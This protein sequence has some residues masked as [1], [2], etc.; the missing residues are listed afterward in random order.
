MFLDINNVDPPGGAVWCSVR[1]GWYHKG[2][3]Q[4]TVFG[5]CGRFIIEDL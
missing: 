2:T 4:A 3:N 5:K 1:I